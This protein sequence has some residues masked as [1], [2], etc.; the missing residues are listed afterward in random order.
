MYLGKIKG[1]LPDL[2]P[3]SAKVNGDKN[4][5][6]ADHLIHPSRTACRNIIFRIL[7]HLGN[8]LGIHQA[9]VV[10]MVEHGTNQYFKGCRRGEPAPLH[11]LRRRCKRQNP[12]C[13]NQTGKTE[14]QSPESKAW[15]VS[16]SSDTSS[17]RDRS[18]SSSSVALRLDPDDVVL[19]GGHHP[20]DIQAYRCAQHPA[21]LM[22]GVIASHFGAAG[23]GKQT[24]QSPFREG[25]FKTLQSLQKTLPQFGRPKGILPRT[26]AATP[27]PRFPLSSS[28]RQAAMDFNSISFD[29]PS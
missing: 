9:T 21:Q 4:P 3:L 27:G 22:V 13:G 11:H 7:P 1:N 18:T 6:G 24:G 15:E 17:N 20:N 2:G 25:L 28:A 16:F 14:R 12:R 26:N 8:P 29:S 5:Y 23:S 19:P 10:K